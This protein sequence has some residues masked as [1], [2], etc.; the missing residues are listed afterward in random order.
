MNRFHSRLIIR[1]DFPFKPANWPFFYGWVILGA[2]V[3]GVLMSLPG[4]T[5]GISVFTDHLIGSYKIDR[6]SLTISYL[7]GT[8]VSGLLV[9]YAGKLYD[10]TG[11]RPIAI[12]A[13]IVLALTLVL[14]S[15]LDRIAMG[16]GNTLGQEYY[17][18]ILLILLTPLFFLLRFS[19]QG[20]TT[21]ISRN[22]VMKWFESRRG[23]ANF[24]LGVI[25]TV[26][27]NATPKF[28]DFLIQ[29]NGWR[30]AWIFAAIFL[31][32]LYIPFL[33]TFFRDNPQGA[34]LLPDG[35]IRSEKKQNK[36]VRF[37]ASKECS[38]K[39][40]RKT[41]EFWLF[42]SIIALLGLFFTGFTFN[43]ESI[44]ENQGLTKEIAMR[45]FI[46]A[47]ICSLITQFIANWLSDYISLRLYLPV[48]SLVLAVN[49]F[50][51]P[52]IK[53][54][55]IFYYGFISLLAISN[56]FFGVF[57]AITWPRL[58]GTRHLGE[59]SGSA[60][61]FVVLASAAGPL[62]MSLS[63]KFTSSYNLSFYLCA[64]LALLLF[65]LSFF[66]RDERK[67]F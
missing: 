64:T 7:I 65:L 36:Q 37:I 44:F 52:W 66:A 12:A 13:A 10:E 8:A 18:P 48:A 54:E 35:K 61:G 2:G 53:D 28:F 26:G 3:F 38:L 4:Q 22:M 56:S 57:T 47:G 11:V 15:Q 51:I 42:T 45:M 50:I 46:I 21:L 58:F 24:F 31:V 43:F 34:G 39:E 40:A 55:N 62:I 49:I 25:T 59:I 20:V 67:I 63:F 1:P 16:L 14:L 6:V 9:R 23:M 19:G 33:I 27:F 29:N 5:T 60:M 17:T 30:K 32:V 41:R